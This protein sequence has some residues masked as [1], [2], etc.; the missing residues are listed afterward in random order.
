[1]LKENKVEVFI[2]EQVCCGV[3]AEASGDEET[4]LHLA[5]ENVKNFTKLQ[6]DSIITGLSKLRG[7]APRVWGKIRD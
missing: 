2:P 7:G 3:P 1:M 5:A 6:V 4:M